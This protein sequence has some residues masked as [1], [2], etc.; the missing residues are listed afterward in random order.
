MT[1]VATKGHKRRK[2]YPQPWGCPLSQLKMKKRAL[3]VFDGRRRLWKGDM[4]IHTSGGETR[5]S[6][7]DGKSY[8]TD[9]DVITIRHAEASIPYT[10]SEDLSGDCESRFD[11]RRRLWKG[12]MMIHTSDGETRV[13]LLDGKSY[14]TDMDVMTVRHAEASIPYTISEDLSGDRGSRILSRISEKNLNFGEI[15]LKVW[16]RERL[17]PFL[18]EDSKL[19]REGLEYRKSFLLYSSETI[20]YS[21]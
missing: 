7:L 17:S 6:L 8:V 13:S 4:M 10:I 12:D 19:R 14:V 21:T 5:V 20:T 1:T 9:M 18:Y 16:R 2:E 11:G 3:C 15:G